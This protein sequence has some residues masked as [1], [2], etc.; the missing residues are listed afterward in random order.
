VFALPQPEAPVPR[1]KLTEVEG[2]HYYNIGKKMAFESRS[3][4]SLTSPMIPLN[5]DI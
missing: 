3:L 5:S 4:I 1:N 2:G